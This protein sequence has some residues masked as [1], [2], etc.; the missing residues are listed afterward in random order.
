MCGGGCAQ[1]FVIAIFVARCLETIDV[2]IMA[3]VCFY[4]CCSDCVGGL[5]ECLLC[6][7]PLL[8]I[9]FFF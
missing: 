7:R 8:K 2:C 5:W 3:H 9:V 4:V 1:Y 6:S